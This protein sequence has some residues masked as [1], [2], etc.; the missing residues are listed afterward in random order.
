MKHMFKSGMYVGFAKLAEHGVSLS[1]QG[2][3]FSQ[4]AKDERLPGMNRWVPR[5]LLENAY[6]QTDAGFDDKAIEQMAAESG[7]VEYPMVGAGLGALLAHFGLSKS[8]G[9]AGLG[10]LVGGG[11]G[12]LYNTATRDQ[13]VGDMHEA[14]KGV[15]GERQRMGQPSANEAVP[16][17]VSAAG[18]DT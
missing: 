4:S 15:H 17:V 2:I 11:A 3:G 14:L 9:A 12:A 7:N 6:A 10:A 1:P 18:G 16:M 8:L 5:Q 13:R